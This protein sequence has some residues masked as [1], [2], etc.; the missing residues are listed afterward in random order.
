[1][2]RF[3]ARLARKDDNHAG[4]VRD[5]RRVGVRVLDLSR[6]GDGCFDL[7]CLFRGRWTF[8]EVKNPRSAYGRAGLTDSQRMFRLLWSDV[9]S[10]P[11][12][13]SAEAFA[14][15]GIRLEAA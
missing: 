13:N 2:S 12:N 5:L 3:K 10:F 15:L 7:L 4:I 14:A 1:M 9:P 6:V 11:V 8:L